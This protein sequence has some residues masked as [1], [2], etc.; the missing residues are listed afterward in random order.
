MEKAVNNNGFD[1]VD[2]DLPSGTLWAACNVGVYVPSG[3]GLYFQ[4]GDVKGYP[5]GQ[6]GI[7]NGKK[8]FEACWSD[9]KFFKNIS[10][11]KYTNIGD[12]LELKDDAANFY[13]G[14]SWHIPSPNQI[15][16]LIDN[17]ISKW[18]TAQNGVNG[19]KFTSKKDKSKSIFIPAAGCAS[20]GLVVDRGNYGIIW[21]SALS[22][23]TAY[24]GQ[25]LFFNS[26]DLRLSK[27]F[28]SDGLSV[29]G[30]IDGNSEEKKNDM[31]ENLNLVEIL[32]D[33]PEGTKL[34]S[35]VCGECK[36]HKISANESYPIECMTKNHAGNFLLVLFTNTGGY[37]LN[38]ADGE[39]VLFPSKENHDWSTFKIPKTTHKHFESFQK[40]L[41]RKYQNGKF[42]WV[43][44]LYSYYDDSIGVHYL[45]GD[46]TVTSDDEIIPYDG[47]EDIDRV[48]E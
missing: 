35:P 19:M 38:F 5:K 8:K 33:V 48:A 9:Y 1:Y 39:C 4:W 34:W 11:S 40:V 29:R 42:M 37:D 26:G 23:D 25:R 10:L 18:K 16:E 14:G 24:W 45:V 15:Q 13:M 46:W 7:G 28:R 6:V 44:E 43:P 21:S 27:G 2:L 22:M 12:T 32:K 41:V 30:V 17:T 3:Y 36:F 20:D 47:N 31:N